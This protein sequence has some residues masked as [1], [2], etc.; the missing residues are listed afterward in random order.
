MIKKILSLLLSAAMLLTMMM[1]AS[2][3]E[4]V[5][6]KENTAQEQS[7]EQKQSSVPV[8]IRA[9]TAVLMD[10]GTGQV[11][12]D[13]DANKPMHPAS[14]TKIMTIL[15]VIEAID[16]GKITINDMVTVSE[17]AA[18]K[19]GSQIWLEVGETMSVDDLLKAAV[20]GSANDACAAL[21]EYIAGSEPAFVTMMNQRAAQLG[22]KNTNFENCSGLDDETV[23]H[24]TTAYDIALMARELIS[25]DIIFKYT[26]IWMDSLRGGKTELTNTNKLIKTFE[27]ITGLKTGTTEKAGYCVCAT[28]KREGMHLIAVVLDGESSKLRFSSAAAMMN[29]GFANYTFVNPQ[30]DMSAITQVKVLHGQQLSI[31]PVVGSPEPVLV[32]KGE[33]ANITQ[34]VELSPDVC[35][36]VEN[37]QVLGTVKF[38]LDGKVVSEAKI[39]AP[40]AVAQMDFGSAYKKIW[41]NLVC[42]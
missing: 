40:E 27:G 26:T 19:G 16:T 9:T 17:D 6:Q 1:P 15:L 5:Q 3:E 35:A 30:I 29:W 25:H 4:P 8:D 32:K 7:G 24:I 12:I 14:I 36:P 2:A 34:T 11:L 10:A 33:E 31:S 21:A 42:N 22:M 37:G 20:V 39:C 41:G 28:A 38:T 23:N 18:K 13:K